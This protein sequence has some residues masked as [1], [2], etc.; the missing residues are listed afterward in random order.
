MIRFGV[1][2]A[3][4]VRNRFGEVVDTAVSHVEALHMVTYW[5]RT[6]PAAGPYFCTPIKEGM[7][8]A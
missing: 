2:P 1:Q 7:A 8:A 6:A 5:T 4:E 3:H